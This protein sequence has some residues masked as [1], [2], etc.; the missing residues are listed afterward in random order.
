MKSTTV[1]FDL[2]HPVLWRTRPSDPVLWPLGRVWE[3]AEWSMVNPLLAGVAELNPF[4]LP[5]KLDLPRIAQEASYV[6]TR[7]VFLV[8][9]DAAKAE[10]RTHDAWD[11]AADSGLGLLLRWVRVR[12]GA[13][14]LVRLRRFQA[15]GELGEIVLPEMEYPEVQHGYYHLHLGKFEMQTAVGLDLLVRAALDARERVPEA[16]QSVALDAVRAY[17]EGDYRNAILYAAIAT[18]AGAGLHLDETMADAA[19][20]ADPKFTWVEREEACGVV[21]ECPMYEG[22]RGRRHDHPD[23]HEGRE[24]RKSPPFVGLYCEVAEFVFGRSLRDDNV[25]LMRGLAKLGSTRNAIAHTGDTRPGTRFAL[26]ADG[27]TE[28]LAIMRSC[29]EWMQ[30]DVPPIVV[31]SRHSERLDGPSWEWQERFGFWRGPTE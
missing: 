22:L 14:G 18:E 28:A 12:S 25:D 1:W 19:R 30:L 5:L 13:A 16:W 2:A 7:R 3:G 17:R 6:R 11:R 15:S 29:L 21:V 8:G 20:A 23:A 24:L 4:G 26:D 9:P 31:V 27:A 10:A